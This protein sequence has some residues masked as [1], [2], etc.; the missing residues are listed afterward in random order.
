[1]KKT[2]KAAAALTAAGVLALTAVLRW[3]SGGGGDGDDQHRRLLR[4]PRPPTRPSSRSSTTPTP[5]R[6]STSRRRTAPPATRAAPSWP[7]GRRL[8]ALLGRDRRDPPGRRRPGRR[9]LE[10][11][12]PPR[13]SRPTSVVVF[14]VRDGQPQGHP[15]LGRPDQAR[16]R[17]RDRQPGLVRRGAL[18]HARRVAHI[19]ENGG[20]EAERVRDQALRQRRRAPTTGRDATTAFSRATATCCSPTRTRRSWPRRAARTSSTSSRTARC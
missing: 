1:M 6:A 7:A 19:T 18:E 8:R 3:R 5:A 14:V 9:G 20:T 10:G 12:T 16:R 2:I 13:A 17:H 15:E 4:A 11:Q